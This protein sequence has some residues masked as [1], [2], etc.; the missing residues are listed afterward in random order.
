MYLLII[1]FDEFEFTIT[2]IKS[3]F[4]LVKD[5]KK[6]FFDIRLSNKPKSFFD[7][8]C[9]SSSTDPL[10]KYSSLYNQYLTDKFIFNKNCDEESIEEWYNNT[11]VLAEELN[12]KKENNKDIETLCKSLSKIKSRY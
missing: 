10:W 6:S 11:G 5:M 2:F 9:Y 4:D 12:Y 8:D 7:F 1:L 3:L